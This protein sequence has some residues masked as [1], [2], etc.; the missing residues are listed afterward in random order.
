MY[1]LVHFPNVHNTQCSAGPK[2]IVRKFILI[3][4]INDRSPNIRA[5]FFCLPAYISRTLDLMWS[6]WHFNWH[7]VWDSTVVA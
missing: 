2:A 6:S 4:H 3:S 1:L 5:I 7:F